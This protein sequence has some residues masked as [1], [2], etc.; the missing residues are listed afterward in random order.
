MSWKVSREKGTI[1]TIPSFHVV[2]YLLFIT[3]LKL[4][5]ATQFLCHRCSGVGVDLHLLWKVSSETP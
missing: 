3:F 5:T 4:G 1:M 2:E